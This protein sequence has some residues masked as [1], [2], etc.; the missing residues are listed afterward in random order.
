M[1]TRLFVATREG[2]VSVKGEGSGSWSV[3]GQWLEDWDVISVAVQQSAPGRV[4]AGTR[5]DGV[6][7]SE[8][9]GQSWRK[10]NYGRPGPGKVRCVIIDPHNSNRIYAGTE[11]I[12]VWTSEDSGDS[13]RT[14]DSVWDVPTVATVNFHPRVHIE[15]HVRD[16]TISIKDPDTIYAALQVGYMLKSKDGGASWAQM[17]GEV[18]ADIHSIV[19]RPDSPGRI[20]VATG[21]GD[22][23]KGKVAGRALYQSPDGG[24]TWSPMAM[25]FRQSYSEPLV[26]HPKDPNILFSA[27]ASDQPRRWGERKDGAEAIVIRSTDGG[28]SWQKLNTSFTEITRNFARAI[29]I[30]PEAPDNIFLATLSGQLFGSE[31]GGEHWAALGVTVPRVSDLKAVHVP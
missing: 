6:Y 7:L 24:E 18:D 31:D 22:G 17:G 26:M 12:A 14:L 11:P 4:F 10:P 20:Y 13:W 30:D 28:A 8:D 1:A 16:I 19:A 2:V 23:R 27:L 9:A 5:G 15:P 3:E 25:E 21:G 29:A